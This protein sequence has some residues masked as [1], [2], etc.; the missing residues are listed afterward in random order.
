M[1]G[2]LKSTYV[3]LNNP[4]SGVDILAPGTTLGI[5]VYGLCAGG[6]RP[7]SASAPAKFAS[8]IWRYMM[9]IISRDYP[10]IAPAGPSFS[11]G[12]RSGNLFFTAGCTAR[13]TIAQGKALM[14]Q[15]RV[16][17]D[18]ITRTVAEEGGTASEPSH[19]VLDLR[20]ITAR[21]CQHLKSALLS[22]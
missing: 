16:T 20:T 22:V 17:L 10:N 2:R 13:G 12:M 3:R 11:R 18:R 7:G 4:G 5:V 15:L 21:R 19:Y 6:G 8:R 14:D 9:A 1:A